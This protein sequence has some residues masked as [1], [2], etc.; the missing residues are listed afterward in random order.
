MTGTF[1]PIPLQETQPS[2]MS[3]NVQQAPLLFSSDVDYLRMDPSIDLQERASGGVQAD[4]SIR[5]STFGQTL[6]LIDGLRVNDTQTGRHNL[7]LPIPL[8]SID[9]IEVLHGAGSTFYG[10]D[11]MGGAVNFITAPAAISQFRIRAGIGNFGYNEQRA[12]ASYSAQKWSEEVTAGRSFSTGFM[13]DRDFRSAAA[14]SETHFRSAL[15]GTTILLSG[16]DR[17]FGATQFYGPFDSW[18]RTKGWFASLTQD[19]GKRTVFDFGYRRHSDEFILL[20][21]APSVYENNHVTD[22][23]QAS[24]RR[25]DEV[26]Q[27]TTV[28]YGVEG[29]RDQIDSNNLGYHVRNRGA[30]Y[31]AVDF[32]ALRR[33]SVSLGAR[34]SRI[35]GLGDSSHLRPALPTGFRLRSRCVAR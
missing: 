28:S 31:A 9:R 30:V 29:Y 4:L 13:P 23:W 14:S 27:N 10:A 7:D 33:F 25:H 18:E 17:P 21:E 6:V 15:G 32:R 22:S 34:R 5:G 8:G 12:V 20:R 11:A 1:E 16:A 24:L 3:I 26:A 2:V 35:T 19:L